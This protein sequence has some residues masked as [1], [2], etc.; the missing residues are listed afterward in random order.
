MRN[1][2]QQLVNYAC[3]HRDPRN[4]RTHLIGV[5]LIVLAVATLLAGVPLA[6]VSVAHVAILLVVLYY[7]RLSRVLGACM[8]VVMLLALWGGIRLAALP[9]P[10]GL[11]TGGGL[12]VLGW[13]FQLLG[14][15]YEGRKPAFVD[16]L[17]GL[18][19]GPLFVLVECLFRLGLLR[20][21]QTEIEQQAG[22]VA[23]RRADH[24]HNG[25]G[26]T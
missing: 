9:P 26:S 24:G 15:V 7:L 2:Q 1:L 17:V 4:I 8:A 20:G 21:L 5:P 11:L 18:L 3:Y 6:G 14:H 13:A 19:I 25:G 22:P 16:D 10:G 23:V 12:F